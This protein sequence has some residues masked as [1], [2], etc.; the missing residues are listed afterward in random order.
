[1]STTTAKLPKSDFAQQSTTD[2]WTRHTHTNRNQ[3]D[4]LCVYV[5]MSV[6]RSVVERLRPQYDFHQI[7]HAAR[8]YGRLDR[9]CF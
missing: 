6:H 1:M 4:C 7:L 3:S 9:Y 5:C 8:K 2:Q